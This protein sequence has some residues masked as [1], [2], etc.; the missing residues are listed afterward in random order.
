MG[1]ET[2]V[3][4][5]LTAEPDAKSVP[6]AVAGGLTLRIK[7]TEKLFEHGLGGLRG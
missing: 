3:V 6:P 2:E 5:P 1:F 7:T 4:L